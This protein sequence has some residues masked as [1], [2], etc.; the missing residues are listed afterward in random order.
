RG[1]GRWFIGGTAV[2]RVVRVV[3]AI[4]GVRLTGVVHVTSAVPAG[5]RIAI[6]RDVVSG[7]L[8]RVVRRRGRLADRRRGRDRPAA[9]GAAAAVHAR[10][11]LRGLHV[12]G[13][14]HLR[15]LV[16]R[17]RLPAAL[18]GRDGAVGGRE[19]ACGLRGHGAGGGGVVV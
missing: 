15:G 17:V 7:V 10:D 14:V 4:G 18:L 2:V 9:R 8:H 12:H 11:R 19:A 13:Q 5:A 6:G 3:R 1:T 16:G